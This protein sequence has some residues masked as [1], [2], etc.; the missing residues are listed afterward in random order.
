MA[1]FDNMLQNALIALAAGRND[2]ARRLLTGL[3]ASNPNDEKGWLYLA[4]ALPREQAIQSLQKVLMINPRHKQALRSLKMLRQNP[5][6]R[7]DLADVMVEEESQEAVFGNEP[8]TIPIS[9]LAAIFGDE[10]PTIPV[11]FQTVLNQK[12][13]APEVHHTPE[14]GLIGSLLAEEWT[15]HPTPRK[16]LPIPQAQPLPKKELP[17]PQAQPP[18]KKEPSRSS[19]WADSSSEE[20]ELPLIA[21]TSS[22]VARPIGNPRLAPKLRAASA[23]FP[24]SSMSVDPRSIEGRVAR[25]IN[26]PATPPVERRP[27]RWV[28]SS[29]LTN[30]DMRLPTPKPSSSRRAY[31]SYSAGLTSFGYIVLIILIIVLLIY[32]YAS[33]QAPVGISTD[34]TPRPTLP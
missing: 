27:A 21:K 30:I 4:V 31:R 25:V 3:V 19:S 23:N 5:D 28:Q 22:E 33:L 9:R 7:L 24:I 2:T 8:A 12:K 20:D 15:A 10:P 13:P 34:L 14:A 26:N 6:A 17:I 29:P 1:D 11:A 32:L 16:E 18:P